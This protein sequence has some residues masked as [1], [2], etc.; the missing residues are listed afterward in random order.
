MKNTIY[1]FTLAIVLVCTLLLGAC[2]NIANT[3][4]SPAADGFGK[5]RISFTRDE[6]RTTFPDISGYNTFVYTFTDSEGTA[7]V[8]EPIEGIFALEA[9]SWTI[10]VEAYIDSDISGEPAAMGT[11]SFTLNPG[12]TLNVFIEMDINPDSSSDTGTFTYDIRFPVGTNIHNIFIASIEAE[13]SFDLNGNHSISGFSGTDDLDAGA[14]ILV[15]LL[16]NYWGETGLCEMVYIYP[17]LET[18]YEKVFEGKNY[19]TI[20]SM[21]QLYDELNWIVD[22]MDYHEVGNSKDAPAILSLEID[23]GNMS[24]YMSNWQQMLQI[25]DDW[26]FYVT[27]DLS[28]CTMQGTE[29]APYK[30]TATGEEFIVSLVLPDAAE[31]IADAIDYDN[32]T[33]KNF[34]NLI[35]ITGKNVISIGGSAF[36]NYNNTVSFVLRNASFPNAK[37]IGEYAFFG[38]EYLESVDFPAVTYIS[39]GA[40]CECYNL[41]SVDFPAVTYI[42]EE[43]FG[44]CFSLYNVNIPKVTDIGGNAFAYTGTIAL[45]ITMGEIPPK[46]STDLF[47]GMGGKTVTVMIP[48]ATANKAAF[49][50]DSGELGNYDNASTDNWGWAFKGEGWNGVMYLGGTVNY[51]ITLKFDLY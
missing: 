21:E 49:G 7:N 10:D 13:A 39:V 45:T 50:F 35:D 23:L 48:D 25:I 11:G 36:D 20:H 43:A 1:S 41:K 38:C 15:I 51:N 30:A 14:Y 46:V 31:S 33:F 19:F 17:G 26:G 42:D 8:I 12:P 28:A 3:P 24:S 32:P 40:F 29:L 16:K 47:D 9:G 5:V 2:N 34:E 4:G 37:S 22:F 18:H 27:L 6:A 44:G